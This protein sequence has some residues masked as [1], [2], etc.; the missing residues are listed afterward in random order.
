M[1][2]TVCQSAESRIVRTDASD[3]EIRRRRECLRCKH[4][5]TTFERTEDALARLDKIAETVRP[6]A[7]LIG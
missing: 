2:C 1:R 4:R 7:D 6:L 5:W 3:A